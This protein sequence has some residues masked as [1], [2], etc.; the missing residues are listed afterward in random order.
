MEKFGINFTVSPKR[1]EDT[2]GHFSAT[3]ITWDSRWH[4]TAS[5]TFSFDM[6]WMPQPLPGQPLVWMQQIADEIYKTV[7]AERARQEAG[8]WISGTTANGET[9]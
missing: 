1:G 7:N 4:C 5:E 3:I 9:P 8:G 6:E 2:T